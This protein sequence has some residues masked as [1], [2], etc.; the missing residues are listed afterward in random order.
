MKL[1]GR[2]KKE[3]KS[4]STEKELTPQMVLV[5]DSK[6]IASSFILTVVS[7]LITLPLFVIVYRYVPDII[8]P[9]GEGLRIDHIL[10][11]VAIF[12]VIRLF[13]A[14]IRFF[15]YG[16]LI[17]MLFVMIVGQISGK[18]GFTKV[19]SDYVDLISFVGTNPI[20]IPFLASNKTTIK[21]ADKILAAIDYRNP[22]VRDFAV[23]SSLQ[24]FAKAKYDEKF[25]NVVKYFS[26]FKTLSKWQYVNDPKGDDYF[27]KA[28]ES[29][30]LMSGDCDDYTI[31]MAASIKAIG[32]EVR[33]VRTLTHLYPE[34]KVCSKEDF[35]A[36]I[37]LIKR[38]LFYKES[39]GGRI[40]FHSDEF[41]NIWLNFDYTEI[42]P[43]GKFMSEEIVG[44]LEIL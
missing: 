1:F 36:I 15:L 17:M 18:Y 41:E 10:T 24:Y 34:V 26:V 4:N 23:S 12:A 43:G 39:L 2:K 19:F 44:I 35:P 6:R 25:R 20:K 28:S 8:I 14:L 5:N 29:V 16:L 40:Y 9:I 32:G 7:A 42:Y 27:A 37:V 38:Q 21:D 33:L 13:V 11:F 30:K 3:I 31:L 22:T